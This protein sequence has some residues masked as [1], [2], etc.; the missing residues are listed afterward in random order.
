[1]CR[2][3]AF[4][5]EESTF[6]DSDIFVFG[7]LMLLSSR[8]GNNDGVGVA[9]NTL[10]KESWIKLG[11]EADELVFKKAWKTWFSE[12]SGYD[13]VFGH[14]RLASAAWR[15]A[16]EK[17]ATKHA[18]P[19]V[20]NGVVGMHNGNFKDYEKIAEQI[21]GEKEEYIDT[22]YFYDFLGQRVNGS[23]SVQD[24]VDTL[25]EVGEANYSLVMRHVGQPEVLVFRGNRPLFVA[26]SNYGLLLNTERENLVDLPWMV[27]PTLE[28]LDRTTLEMETPSPLSEY[29]AYSLL[30]GALEELGKFDEVRS[31]NQPPV[32]T[33]HYS[34]YKS[35]HSGNSSVA[36]AVSET[37][38]DTEILA[39]AKALTQIKG[40]NPFAADEDYRL[41]MVELY[42]KEILDLSWAESEQLIYL[43]DLMEWATELNGGIYAPTE[44]KNDLWSRFSIALYDENPTMPAS[45]VYRTA[46][47]LLSK[48]FDVPYWHNPVEDLEQLVE[49]TTGGVVVN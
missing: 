2:L 39:R 7:W 19:H 49:V 32:V 11:D 41:T 10:G 29:T 30:R 33:T 17:H 1:M 5:K 48:P 20:F 43:A 28:H 15:S 4:S 36:A 47:Y 35:Y 42:G 12:I 44:M 16:K 23:L 18:H 9:T 6:T 21:G 45:E 34:G 37:L 46:G 14:A 26:K 13:T 22:Q 40:I 25:K 3:A 31:I 24:V 8:K 27:N 38:P